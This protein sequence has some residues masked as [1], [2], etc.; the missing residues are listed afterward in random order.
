MG[1]RHIY[2]HGTTLPAGAASK[3]LRRPTTE[4]PFFVADKLDIAKWYIDHYETFNNVK[5]TSVFVL[6]AKE[7]LDNVS[8]YFRDPSHLS[9]LSRQFPALVDLLKKELPFETTFFNVSHNLALLLVK[10]FTEKFP[11]CEFKPVSKE[12]EEWWNKKTPLRVKALTSMG[13]IERDPVTK[14]LFPARIVERTLKNIDDEE[15]QYT[16]LRRAIKSPV[17][18]KIHKLGYPCVKEWDTTPYNDGWEYAVFDMDVFDGG[19]SNS[20]TRRQ[21]NKVL[22]DIEE[23]ENGSK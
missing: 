2:F 5:A 3:E 13:F 7:D 17:F 6:E 21:A 23:E 10:M 4:R 19:W 14:E 22:M 16:T 8:F 9:K 15:K 12:N 18:E 20:L 11:S 1:K